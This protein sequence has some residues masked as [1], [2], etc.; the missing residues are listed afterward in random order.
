MGR[1]SPR[2]ATLHDWRRLPAPSTEAWFGSDKPCGLAP[3]W[4]ATGA[5]SAAGPPSW[6]AQL[7][8]RGNQ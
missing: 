2:Q 1:A 7:G 6:R 8:S 3:T 5:M 4:C